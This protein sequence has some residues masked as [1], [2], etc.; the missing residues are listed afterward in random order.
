MKSKKTYIIILVVLA[1]YFLVLYLTWGRENIKKNKSETTII[2]GD[3]TIWNK[4]GQ[5]WLNLTIDSSIDTLN[6]QEFEVFEDNLKIGKYNLWHD[7]K[8]YVFDKNKNAI[9]VAGKLLAFKGN[10]NLQVKEFEEKNITDFSVVNQV[11]TENGLNITSELTS[12]V[13]V[14]FDIDNDNITESFYLISNVFPLDFNPE[15][16]FSIVFMVKDNNIYYLY[17]DVQNNKG[18][19]EGCKPYIYSILDVNNDNDYEI[20]LSCGKYSNKKPLDMLYDF[21]TEGFKILI[22]NQ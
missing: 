19:N 11:L 7:D 14:D 13:Q 4:S 9:S 1:V 22:S 2:V 16:I 10:F 15:V 5:K 18:V 21:S 20:I 6:W 3:S 8:W 17:K 12:Q